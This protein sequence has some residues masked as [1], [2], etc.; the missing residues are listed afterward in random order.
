MSPNKFCASSYHFRDIQ[1]LYFELQKDKSR[2][3]NA[4]FAITP[5]SDK[6]QNPKMTHPNFA[7]ALTISD[8]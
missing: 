3:Q 4:I 5:F 6:C 2:S 7:L 8:I 1:I